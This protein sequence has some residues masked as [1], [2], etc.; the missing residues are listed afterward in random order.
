MTENIPYVNNKGQMVPT[1][2]GISPYLHGIYFCLLVLPLDKPVGRVKVY[3][4][5]KIHA[6]IAC[7]SSANSRTVE[8]PNEK[9]D[10]GI[11]ANQRTFRQT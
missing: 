2:C 4:A 7:A 5:R 9:I 1:L 6:K 3:L 10:R 11:F 8:K